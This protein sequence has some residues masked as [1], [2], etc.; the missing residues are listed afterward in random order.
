MLG[1]GCGSDTSEG[2]GQLSLEDASSDSVGY[3]GS[4]VHCLI[5]DRRQEQDFME[6]SMTIES[7]NVFEDN[8]EAIKLVVNKHTSSSAKNIV[9]NTSL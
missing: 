9:R 1:I 3:L 4:G 7:V 2:G 5:R 8:E 6:P